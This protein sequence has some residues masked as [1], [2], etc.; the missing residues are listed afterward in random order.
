MNAT[1][2][3]LRRILYVEDNPDIVTVARFALEK[4]GGLEVCFCFSA[5]EALERVEGFEP[6]MIV[7]DVMLPGMDG[8][9]LL[10]QLRK[11]DICAAIPIVFITAKAQGSDIRYL[12]SLGV[13]GVI[14]K[15]FDA[16]NLAAQLRGIWARA[17]G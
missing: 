3:A 15:P 6:E 14:A 8:P 13:A 7:L 10:L 16:V 2:G 5:D 4:I 1:V 9:A 17:T 11:L 12:D